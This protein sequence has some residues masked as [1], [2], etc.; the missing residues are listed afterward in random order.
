MTTFVLVAG[1]WHGAWT[2]RR[3][4]AIL[5]SAGHEVHPVTLTGLGDRAHLGRPET[6]LGD[7]VQDVLAT[8]DA[9][10]LDA[11]VL[12]GHSYAGHVVGNVAAR[13]PRRIAHVVHLDSTLPADG[14]SHFDLAPP[15]LRGYAE[16][17]ARTGGDGWRWPWPGREGFEPWFGDLGIA[18]E[19]WR[20]L[21]AHSVGH[22]IATM[23]EPSPSGVSDPGVRR[24]YV[25][26]TKGPTPSPVSA[27]DPD[28]GY[29]EV[30]ANHW[31]MVTHPRE[32]AEVLLELG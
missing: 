4:T 8:L 26:C 15:E 32:V 29:A 20:W 24:T 3:V 30:D 10:E 2:W 9:E 22:P 17:S 23:R 7:H 5:R 27:D 14:R 12:V 28:W 25:Y 1:A 13:A 31:A 18:D 6:G 21:D 19:D 11:V 16:E